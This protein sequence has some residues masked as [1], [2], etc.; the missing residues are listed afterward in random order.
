MYVYVN[1]SRGVDAASV[2]SSRKHSTRSSYSNASSI[3]SPYMSVVI[4]CNISNSI[5]NNV[6]LNIDIIIIIILTTN[7]IIVIIIIFMF[8]NIITINV[9]ISIISI[10]TVTITITVT[11]VNSSSV[12]HLESGTSAP[13]APPTR[14]ASGLPAIRETRRFCHTSMRNLLGRLRLGWLTRASVHTSL[15]DVIDSLREMITLLPR[16]ASF[17]PR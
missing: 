15:L 4:S 1:T 11:T 5:N 17:R 13:E 7:S 3:G 8:N 9:I 12:T 10:I 6:N 14:A 16:D 2:A